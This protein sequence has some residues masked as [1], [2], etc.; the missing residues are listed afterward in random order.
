LSIRHRARRI[1][2]VLVQVEDSPRRIALAFAIGVWIAFFP[3]LGIH[4]AM[5]LIVGVTFRLS[6]VA[7]LLGAYVSNPWTFAPLY[8]AGTALGCILLGVSPAELW[9]LDW[10]VGWAPALMLAR[11]APL[12][13]PFVVGNLVLGSLAALLAYGLVLRLLERRQAPVERAA[14]QAL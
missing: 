2:H 13:W 5:A 7:L 11:L 9:A 1:V 14:S 6:R 4:T 10:R 8:S 3:L 12:L